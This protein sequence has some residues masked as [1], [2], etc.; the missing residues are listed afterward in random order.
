MLHTAIAERSGLTATDTKTIDTLIR[1]GPALPENSLDTRGSRRASVTSLIDRLEKRNW[2][3]GRAI[4]EIGRR[5]I[6]KPVL[7]RIADC[8]NVFRPDP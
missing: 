2:S 6:V 7:E 8:Q 3:A 5:V 1:L 4:R